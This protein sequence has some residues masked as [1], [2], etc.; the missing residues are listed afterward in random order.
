VGSVNPVIPVTL[1][2]YIK[3]DKS[4]PRGPLKEH[5]HRQEGAMEGT[6]YEEKAAEGGDVTI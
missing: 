1:N 4:G 5:V 6:W 2:G 3:I